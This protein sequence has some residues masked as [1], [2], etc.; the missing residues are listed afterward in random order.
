MENNM[1]NMERVDNSRISSTIRK[2]VQQIIF[3]IGLNVHENNNAWTRLAIKYNIQAMLTDHETRDVISGYS[4]TCDS[5]NNGPEI[6]DANQLNVDIK[7]ERF[8]NTILSY[9]AVTM[10]DD[11]HSLDDVID[12]ECHNDA[13]FARAMK[14]V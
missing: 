13:N 2:Q 10:A 7:L 14:G 4:V 9:R 8:N 11:D 12:T 3:A 1:T 5:S 6:V